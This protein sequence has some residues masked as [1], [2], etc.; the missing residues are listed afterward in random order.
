[1]TAITLAADGAKKRRAGLAAGAL[2]FHQTLRHDQIGLMVL[3]AASGRETIS[4]RE[5]SGALRRSLHWSER[6][7]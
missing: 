6:P 7:P 4:S 1:V 3:V 5:W 2:K